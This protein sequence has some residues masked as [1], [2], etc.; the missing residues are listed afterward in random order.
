MMGFGNNFPFLVHWLLARVQNRF[1]D[2][3][4]LPQS[5]AWAWLRLDLHQ[6]RWSFAALPCLPWD[7]SEPMTVIWPKPVRSGVWWWTASQSETETLVRQLYITVICL[8]SWPCTTRIN[9]LVHRSSD[10]K[11]NQTAFMEG[12]LSPL[13]FQLARHTGKDSIIR[14]LS[15]A[16]DI[17]KEISWWMIVG[18]KAQTQGCLPAGHKTAAPQERV[19]LCGQR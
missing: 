2:A 4:K 11:R 17:T 5:W 16:E 6:S 9:K 8:R 1:A 18:L 19:Q 3:Y 7:S 12:S 15:S 10:P 14:P 13:C